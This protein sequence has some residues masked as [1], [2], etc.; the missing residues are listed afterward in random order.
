MITRTSSKAVACL[1]CQWRSFSV[2]YRLLAE[3]VPL[4]P[5]GP[6]STPTPIPTPVTSATVVLAALDAAKKDVNPA[7]A[8]APRAYGKAL[9]E[10][11][12]MPLSRP[13]G[14]HSPPNAG[15]NTGIDKRSLQQRRDDF[16]DY[17]KHIVRREQL[18]DLTYTRNENS[19][20]NS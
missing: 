5:S 4:S 13:I 19:R 17:D 1:L 12:P 10:F 7:L 20:S 3:K 18:Y 8:N 6:P 16:V 9:E 15:E 14:M 2:S 11:T